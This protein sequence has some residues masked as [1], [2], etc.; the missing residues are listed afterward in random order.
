MSHGDLPAVS[1]QRWNRY[2]RFVERFI[3]DGLSAEE[4][5]RA[6][7]FVTAWLPV[8]PFCV[9]AGAWFALTRSWGMVGALTAGFWL[10]LLML[11]LLK[12]TRS[13]PL[14]AHGSLL[15]GSLL[16][17]VSGLTQ[18][19]PDPTAPTVL[20]VVPLSA[21][22]VLGR[23]AGWI[24][25]GLS[26][27]IVT[28]TLVLVSRGVSLPYRDEQ[29]VVTQVLNFV[30]AMIVVLVFA[31]SADQMRARVIEEQQAA[32][33]TKSRF[34]A[35]ISHEI[36]TPMHGVLGMTEELL[37]TH[38]LTPELAERIAIIQRS[39]HQ[40]VSLINDLLD[41]TKIDA[42]KLSLTSGP[43]DVRLVVG[44]VA[45][46]FTP[47]AARKDLDFQT[48]IEPAVPIWISTDSLRLKQVLTNL[49]SN[50]VKF[51]ETGG[52]KLEARLVDGA[53]LFQVTDTG[54]GIT[55]EVL[56]RLFSAFEQGD[57][58]S[59][60]RHGGTGLG[61]ALSR[62]LVSLL[63]GALTVES[64]KGQGSSFRITMPV[65]AA[66]GSEVAAT[67][68]SP[69]PAARLTVL[70][71]DDNPINRRVAEGLLSRAGHDVR[72]AANGQEAIDA[73]AAT[74]IDAVLMDCHMPVMDGFEATE[75]IRRLDS[76]RAQTPII[77][78]T[79]S[80]S[81]EDR[82]AC[83][84]AGM[85]G[86]LAKPVSFNELVEALAAVTPSARYE[87]SSE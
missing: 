70:V 46:L 76:P 83:Q 31:R 78:V 68:P 65:V 69:R 38:A 39:G 11:W 22:F 16:F 67:L 36:R 59:T 3:P 32:A 71:V 77:A 61:L 8:F 2:D 80:A 28:V 10:G 52:V 25:L 30:Y 14:A 21:A 15:V 6:R 55:A 13:L 20:V 19:P 53:L 37:A 56:P 50:A 54:V 41:L 74:P 12:A 45:A 5:P 33:K 44:D 82:E 81:A 17:A 40:M 9:L 58:S 42:G 34:L 64:T 63:G 62:Q 35:N 75:R 48:V 66:E 49:V 26:I 27:V 86:F 43:T 57:P 73:I 7:L 4:L 72:S 85:N 51:T 79:A 47:L 29:P 24:W 23:R 87:R 18:T 84:R 60:R 1:S